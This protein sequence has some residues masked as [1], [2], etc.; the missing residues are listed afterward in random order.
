MKSKFFG[1]T[2][3][4]ATA[5]TKKQHVIQ[6]ISY[7]RRGRVLRKFWGIVPITAQDAKT[8]YE[9]DQDS[10]A[11]LMMICSNGPSLDQKE[12]VEKFLL[13]VVA[14]F[15]AFKKRVSMSSVG[16][17]PRRASASKAKSSVLSELSG[18]ENVVLNDFIDNVLDSEDVSEQRASA[19]LPDSLP[20]ESEE[21]RAARGEDEMAALD[22]VG[23][24]EADPTVMLEDMPQ[25]IVFKTLKVSCACDAVLVFACVCVCTRATSICVRENLHLH[26]LNFV[27]ACACNREGTSHTSS[28]VDG[29]LE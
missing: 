8:V 4:E 14:R 29:R 21:D 24:Y 12:V 22:A 25:D 13:A 3:D 7:W 6:Y 5:K 20:I 26:F 2:L 10:L 17:R 18:L 23:D 16:K 28:R 15:K 1:H 9:S 27:C 11:C 19:S